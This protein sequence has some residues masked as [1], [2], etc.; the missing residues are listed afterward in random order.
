M[1]AG[2]DAIPFVEFL[3]VSLFGGILGMTGLTVC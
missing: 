2:K 3:P 1:R